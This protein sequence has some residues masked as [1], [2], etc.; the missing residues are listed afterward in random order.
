MTT[1]E[2]RDLLRSTV[3]ALIDS[4]S[5]QAAPAADLEPLAEAE[6]QLV[7]AIEELGA[8]RL[9]RQQ[10]LRLGV[11]EQVADSWPYRLHVLARIGTTD[12][13]PPACRVVERAGKPQDRALARTVAT[14]QSDPRLGQLEADRADRL[15]TGA[16]QRHVL[17][18]E[19]RV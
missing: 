3:A 13:Y 6:I 14:D 11:L 16:L 10:Q 12:E 17:E 19:T 1:P 8:V 15:A 5:L 18:D 4:T 9:E 2:D 7:D